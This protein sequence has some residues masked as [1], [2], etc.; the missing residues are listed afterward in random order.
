MSK[1]QFQGAKEPSQRQL[2]VGEE[3]RHALVQALE[4]GHV[5][6]PVLAN[7]TITVTEVRISPDLK[8][9]TAFVMPLGGGDV[10]LVVPALERAASYLRRE[11]GR[12]VRLRYVPK[13]SFKADQSFD[14]AG[15][16]ED[17]LRSPEVQRDLDRSDSGEDG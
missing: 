13:L 3:L 10:D 8:N 7:H 16:I 11:V 6:D 9:A 15:Q 2:R 1:S 4:R 5:H 14:E 12:Q 17:L